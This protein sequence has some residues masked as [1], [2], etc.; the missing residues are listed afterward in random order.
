MKKGRKTIDCV[1]RDVLLDLSNISILYQI[2]GLRPADS[3]NDPT[4]KFDWR[5]YSIK[6]HTITAPG[7]L[8]QPINPETSNS[9][10]LKDPIFYLLDSRMLV[11]LMASIFE[12]LGTVDLKLIPKI[13]ISDEFP[14]R[15]RLGTLSDWHG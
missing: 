12:F 1:D 8:I 11:A 14:Y 7:C 4:L 3:N 6:E 2:L 10:S 13:E 9:K 5:T 15:E